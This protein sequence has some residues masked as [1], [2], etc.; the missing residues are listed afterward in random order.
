L[1]AAGLEVPLPALTSDPSDG[2][3]AT[4]ET[5]DDPTKLA[6]LARQQMMDDAFQEVFRV[7]RIEAAVEWPEIAPEPLHRRMQATDMAIRTGTLSDVE[8]RALVKDTL[9]GKWE[10]LPEAPPALEDL[11]VLIRKEAE[12]PEQV[13]PMSRGDHSLRDEGGQ[14]HTDNA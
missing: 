10:D 3:R 14:A 11:P 4:A 9:G 1:V 12:G 7:I 5:L 6:M 2:N 8:S 13:D